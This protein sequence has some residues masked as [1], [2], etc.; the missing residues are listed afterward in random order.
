M[1][2]LSSNTQKPFLNG[3]EALDGALLILRCAGLFL[4]ATF[5]RQKCLS[6]WNQ[7]HS[8]QPL[9]AWGLTRFLWHFGFPA[10]AFFAVLAA[11]NESLVSL[12]ITVGLLTRLSSFVAAMGM[13]VAFCISVKLGEDSLRAFLYLFIFAALSIMGPGR[14]SIDYLL[15]RQAIARALRSHS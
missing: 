13:A 4:A 10:P 7:L 6:L 8:G 15:D 3:C 1:R 11:L 2:D 12:M 14:I 5:G 9:S